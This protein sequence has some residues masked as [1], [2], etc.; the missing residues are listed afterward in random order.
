MFA[1][2][3]SIPLEALRVGCEAFAS[4][5]N[6]VAALMLRVLL[7][8]APRSGSDIARDLRREAERIQREVDC[9]LRSCYTTDEGD[10]EPIAYLWARTVR[11][12]NPNCGAEIPIYRAP[13]LAK[14]GASKARYFKESADG[15]CTALC[16]FSA[17]S[18]QRFHPRLG[19]KRKDFGH[20]PDPDLAHYYALA[21]ILAVNSERN[22]P[23]KNHEVV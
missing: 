7:V 21:V 19:S 20:F 8:D 16:E 1:G 22:T 5:S 18:S 10:V 9:T 3:G 15:F 23:D 13:W 12:E 14:R 6:P 17:E 11:C 4:D 2:G